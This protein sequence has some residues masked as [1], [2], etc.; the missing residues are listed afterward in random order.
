MCNTCVLRHRLPCRSAR[1]RC[2]AGQ[3]LST[4]GQIRPRQNCGITVHMSIF[5]E[6]ASNASYQ[7][8]HQARCLAAL[9]GDTDRNRFLV[10]S[11]VLRDKNELHVLDF[12]EDTNEICC[13]RIYTHP[14]EI[15]GLSSCPVPERQELLM[16][17]HSTGIEQRTSL[18]RMD[19]I[20]EHGEEALIG[21][22]EE[23]PQPVPTPEPMSE[24]LQLGGPMPPGDCCGVLWNTL[25]SE[26]IAT[27]Q[28]SQARLWQLSHG[29]S[30]FAA[31][32]ISAVACPV[33]EGFSC[34]H[35]DPHHAHSI[36]LA[37][38]GG[39]LFTLDA[40]CMKFGT[41]Q[42]RRLHFYA[43]ACRGVTLL[44]AQFSSQ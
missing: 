41:A 5:G 28:R 31:A 44:P 7:L 38:A 23:T 30:S 35:W 9:E 21:A 1:A 14:S 22:P 2:L 39:G 25:L 16:T 29:S 20:A 12:N 24:L 18:W 43:G 26:K 4:Q 34:G 6:L 13:Q 36:A 15:W 3:S 8:N 11:L 40:R 33:D 17:T 32:E 19:G 37:T 27:V 10:A 42:V